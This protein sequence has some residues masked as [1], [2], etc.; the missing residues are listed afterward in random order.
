MSGMGAPLTT[1]IDS[2]RTAPGRLVDVR[3]P[4]E[5]Q[6]GHWPGAINIPL[7]SD[8]Q[9]SDVG[10]L[11]KRVGREQAIQRG[12]EIVGP[13]MANLS[14][15]LQKAAGDSQNLRIYCWRGGMRSNSMA[16]LANL[17]GQSTLVLE[18][19]YK[20]YRR[21]VLNQFSQ[22]WPIKLLGGRTGSGK[23]DLL[24]ALADHDVAVVDLEGLAH[25]RGSSFGGLGLPEQPSTEH[26]ENRLAEALDGHRCRQAKEIWL[27]AESA[28]VGRCRIPRDLFVQM[29]AADV[30]EIRRSA[31]ERVDQLVAV[32]GHQGGDALAEATERISRRLGPQRTRQALEAI[33]RHDWHE[34]CR[35]MLDY[36]DRCYDHELAQANER[37]SVDLTGEDPPIAARRLVDEG[38]MRPVA[39]TGRFGNA[40][41]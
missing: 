17:V 36:Y 9:R 26:Y 4:G 30:L 3:S 32:Y 29:Q 40:A 31:Q 37:L 6:Q 34:A 10:T 5:F 8:E 20:S 28:Q 39:S 15:A 16:W 24:L 21:W 23:T 19:G 18:G 38:L 41:L 22:P 12:L 14:E 25:H 2:F 13:S 11:Y 33:Q 35:A 1:E 7:F 27:E